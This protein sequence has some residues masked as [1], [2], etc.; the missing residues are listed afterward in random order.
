MGLFSKRPS[1]DPMITALRPGEI[2]VFGSNSAGNHAGGAARQAAREFGA[3]MGQPGGLQGQSY[4]IVSMDGLEIL[5]DEARRF[6]D[7]ARA[8]PDLSFLVTEIG[9][10]IAGYTPSQVAPF[11]TGAPSNVKLPRSFTAVLA[12]RVE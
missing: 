2:F 10:G 9:C 4:A 11:F 6:L 7:F 8:H 5:G 12:D 3:V 1:G